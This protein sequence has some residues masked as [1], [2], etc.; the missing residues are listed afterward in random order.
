MAIHVV[1]LD[2]CDRFE[3]DGELPP[4]VYLRSD[5]G[6]ENNN[7]TLLAICEL[8]VSRRLVKGAVFFERLPVGHTHE[9]ID[10]IFSRIWTRMR[11]I[12][13]ITPQDYK[14]HVTDIFRSKKMAT[15]TET[16]F[17]FMDILC[18]PDY[19]KFI[20]PFIDPEFSRIFKEQWTQ[21]SIRFTAA[22]ISADFP[23]GVEVHYRAYAQDEVFEIIDTPLWETGK[24]V[25][26]CKVQWQ[27][28][29][30][31]IYLLRGLPAGEVQPA[32]FIE[33]SRKEIETAAQG[34]INYYENKYDGC[35][36][37]YVS[38]RRPILN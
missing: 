12:G 35:A 33:G 5:G 19:K 24:G 21:L 9:D 13:V 7:R 29:G 4:I 23:T 8:L 17:K 22:E 34:I 28:E 37:K 25:R 14:R 10:G 38:T 27:P 1:L 16:K 6:S 3:R 26:K 36:K 2:L 11:D 20:D 32:P 18:L 15:A 31:G 30:K